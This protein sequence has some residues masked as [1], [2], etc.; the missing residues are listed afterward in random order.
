MFFTLFTNVNLLCCAGEKARGSPKSVRF[1]LWTPIP[2][3]VTIYL[4]DVEIYHT[5]GE[6][7]DLLVVL[8]EKSEV[9]RVTMAIYPIVI[10]IL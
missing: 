1:I 4:T 6:N 2:D 7:F 3:F 10:A 8:E 5:V 9:T